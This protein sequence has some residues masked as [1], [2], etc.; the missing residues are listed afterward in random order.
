[1]GGGR[2]GRGRRRRWGVPPVHYT[3]DSSLIT[4]AEPLR[5]SHSSSLSPSSTYK[6]LSPRWRQPI[7]PVPTTP[8]QINTTLNTCPSSKQHFLKWSIGKLTCL[9]LHFSG[10]VHT[11]G[12]I[13]FF[14]KHSF[15]QRILAFYPHANIFLG[16]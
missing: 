10:L 12:G 15:Y 9:C 13:F 4:P 1:M 11:F 16:H 5:P 7:P 14:Y 2:A 6:T 8:T 3:P